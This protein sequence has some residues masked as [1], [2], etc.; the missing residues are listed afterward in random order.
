MKGVVVG[1][2]VG[3][4]AIPHDGCSVI[5]I[6]NP[7]VYPR[8]QDIAKKEADAPAVPIARCIALF[9]CLLSNLS[10]QY[11]ACNYL[12]LPKCSNGNTA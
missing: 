3:G 1:A 10:A 2:G 6:F 11:E 5:D 7:P 8:S 9:Y 12:E 4:Y